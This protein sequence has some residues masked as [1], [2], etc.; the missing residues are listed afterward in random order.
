MSNQ[1][2]ENS[3]K[4]IRY[5]TKKRI[6]LAQSCRENNYARNYIANVR[7]ELATLVANK[8]VT[9]QE[10]KAFRDEYKAWETAM[11]SGAQNNN[12]N[13]K[14]AR[15]EQMSTKASSKTNRTSSSSKKKAASVAT[16]KRA[17]R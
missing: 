9:R 5:A 12:R 14:M 4:L 6:S 16:S 1:R 13:R 3:V 7:Y 15:N 17:S 8:A 2:L 10:A 11:R